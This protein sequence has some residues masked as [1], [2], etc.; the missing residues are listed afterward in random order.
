MLRKGSPG[1]FLQNL[2]S[3]SC[4]HINGIVRKRISIKITFQN[5]LLLSCMLYLDKVTVAKY[6]NSA[7]TDII[8]HV[9]G[10]HFLMYIF[11][12]M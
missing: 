8:S 1:M 6:A 7:C 11:F 2:A 12:R 9:V 4:V 10:V 5:L 3:C